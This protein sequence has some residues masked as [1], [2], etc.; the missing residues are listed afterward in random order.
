[1]VLQAESLSPVRFKLGQSLDAHVQIDAADMSWSTKEVRWRDSGEMRWDDKITLVPLAGTSKITISL[2][3]NAR[4]KRAKVL[5]G[6][7]EIE[8]NELLAKRDRTS[9]E[10]VPD[11]VL[12]LQ[13]K[14]RDNCKVTMRVVESTATP[15][16]SAMDRLA[17]VPAA[18]A[19]PALAAAADAISSAGEV[20][21]GL[22]QS[23]LVGSLASLVESMSI[24]VKIGDEIA[25]IHPWANLAWNVLSVGLKMVRAQQDRDDNIAHLVSTM[26]STYSIVVGADVLKD[27]HLQD[28]LQRI[29]KQTVVCGFFVQNYARRSSF[30]GKAIM[31]AFSRTD[32]LV[33]QYQDAF[34]RMLDEYRGRLATH[35]ALV[36]VTLTT[37]VN[38][39]RFDQLVQKLRPAL[40][41]QTQRDICLPNTRQD[42]IKSILDW[43]SDDSEG[44]ESAMWL[45][46]LAGA[47]K[48]TLSTTIARMMNRIDGI[49]LLG[50]FFFFDRNHPEVNASTVIRTIAYQL[51]EFD[52]IIGARIAEIIEAIP[53]IASQPLSVQFSKLLSDAALGNVRWSG[54]P[55]LIVIDALDEAGTEDERK[56][57]MRALSQGVSQLPAFL[58]ILIVSRRERDILEEFKNSTMRHAELKVNTSSGREDIAAFIRSRLSEIREANIDYIPNQLKSWP[59]DSEVDSLVACASGHF[60]W[61]AT[62]CRLIGASSDPKETMSELV[63]NQSTDSSSAD[64]FS[65]LH[66]LYKTALQSTN[67]WAEPSFCSDFR[68]ILGVIVCAQVPLSCIAIDSVLASPAHRLPSLQTLSR[69][70]SV[71]DWSNTGPIRILHA[72][73]YDYLTSHDRSE[74]WAIDVEQCK[75]Q[76]TYGCVAILERELHENMCSLVLPV[77]IENQTLSEGV[78]YASRFW[79]EHVCSITSPS[80]DLA[81]AIYQLLHKHLLHWMETLAIMK[82]YDIVLRSLSMLFRWTQTLQKYFAGG[83]LYR[84]V[85]DAQRFAQCFVHT[86]NEHPLLIYTSALTFTPKDTLIYKTFHHPQLPRVVTGSETI[87]PPQLQ[88]LQGHKGSVLSVAFSPDG[89]KIVSGSD[90]KTVRVWDVVTGQLAIPPLQGHQGYVWSVAFSPDGSRI[91][92]GSDDQTVRVWDAVTGQLAIPPLRGHQGSVLSVAFSPDGSKIV[93]GSSDRTVRVWDA[94]TGQ[95]VFPPLQGHQAYV[96]SVAFS[97]DG[98]KIVSG[99]DDQSIHVWDTVTGQPAFPPLRGHEGSVLSVAFS[100]DGSKIVS[101]S[102]DKTVRVWDAVTGLLVFPPFQRHEDYVRSVAF[103]P[104]GSKIVSGSGDRTVRVWD[105][106]TGRLA[107]PTLQGDQGYVWSVAFS[108]DGSKIVSGSDDQTVRVWDAVTGQRAFLPLPGHEESVNSVAFSPDGSKIVSG[109]DDKTVRVWDAVT[110]QPVFPPLQGHQGSVLS[111]VFSPDGSKIVSGSDDQTVRVW[112]AVTGKQAFPPLQGHEG[113]V[114]SVAFSPD[115]SKIVSG[116]DDKTVRVWDPVTGQSAL[117]PFLG[118]NDVVESVMY[119]ADGSKIISGSAGIH[120]RVWDATTGCL[121]VPPSRGLHACMSLIVH[122]PWGP[123]Q[124]AESDSERGNDQPISMSTDGIDSSRKGKAR[125]EL[126][127]NE[128]GFFIDV[129]SG[130][131]LCK[132]PLGFK[133]SDPTFHESCCIVWKYTPGLHVPVIIHF[134]C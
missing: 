33:A 67:K 61:A 55:I 94:V 9:S 125:V 16:D 98:S 22:A 12:S 128:D 50:A 107:F 73:F 40:M 37:T 68:R 63:E 58:R 130:R 99:S 89:S 11:L 90:D 32:A 34:Q 19:P 132:I 104:D 38:K 21:A 14:N 26:Q 113:S 46:G 24:M 36:T 65:S 82:A 78:S 2:F 92:S 69:F 27:T 70:G 123:R 66:Q 4:L 95:L 57:L 75:T 129:S 29:L 101:G 60:I 51:A 115:G 112:D 77:P 76:L 86:I 100:P 134:P 131:Y 23:D 105:A 91:V 96:W 106:I 85:H 97:P 117:P 103:S 1:M 119:S 109:S 17:E 7:Q 13:Q 25:K 79:A 28:V 83:H 88:V 15:L 118:H 72:S 62:A 49:N 20:V 116:S 56:D 44:H 120:I 110:G 41:D 124:S 87:W 126:S 3:R 52:A 54:G 84:L 47:G 45:Y 93:S 30:T 59:E 8:L 18:S 48:S 74:P 80:A 133:V 122:P 6:R 43:Y 31:E 81:D 53:D 10:D 102:S 35:T 108:P 39:I 121:W 111:V 127:L 42:V 71:I 114:N 5:V 64:A